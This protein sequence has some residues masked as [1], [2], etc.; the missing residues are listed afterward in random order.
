MCLQKVVVR[1][2]KEKRI[3][4]FSKE[5]TSH[6]R[7]IVLKILTFH[8][9]SWISCSLNLSG[10]PWLS[11]TESKGLILCWCVCSSLLTSFWLCFMIAAVR[12]IYNVFFPF[13]EAIKQ[14][15]SRTAF[16]LCDND[17]IN[18]SRRSV[19]IE[20]IDTFTYRVII[21]LKRVLPLQF[22]NFLTGTWEF[23]FWLGLGFF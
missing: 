22:L 19:P 11:G 20:V 12:L 14:T 18:Q 5:N 7:A 2:K 17:A 9:G 4:S 23:F 13:K 8:F 3:V 15:I 1:N 21:S 16:W 10:V 6:H